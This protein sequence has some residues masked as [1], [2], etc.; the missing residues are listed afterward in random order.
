M[1]AKIGDYIQHHVASGRLC[2]VGY[3]NGCFLAHEVACVLT[4]R[5]CDAQLKLIYIDPL[6]ST[7][8]GCCVTQDVRSK[9]ECLM[10]RILAR[11]VT[12][13]D[14]HF[15]SEAELQVLKNTMLQRIPTLA[16]RFESMYCWLDMLSDKSPIGTLDEVEGVLLVCSSKCVLGVGM[17]E[18]VVSWS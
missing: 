6:E 5:K 1:A 17:H 12:N 10:I 13:D 3:S 2:L 16:R 11:A 14:L 9:I 4:D 7:A 18:R 15:A 8:I